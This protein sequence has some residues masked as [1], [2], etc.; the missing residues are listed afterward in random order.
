MLYN[1]DYFISYAHIDNQSENGNPG[2]VDQFV[3]KLQ[4]SAKH[5]QLF[6][7]KVNV[8]FDKTVIHN[9]SDWDNL[10]RSG[11]ASSRFLI[12]L[13]S[14]AFFKSEYCARVF[15]W[16]MQHE[17]HR[18]VLGE[19]TVPLVIADVPG[20]YDFSD[21]ISGIPAELLARYPN[22]LNQI[23]KIQSDAEFDLRNFDCSKIDNVLD[24]LYNEI[25]DRVDRQELAESSPNN[26]LYP[27]YNQ[28]FV[29]RRENLIVL[30]KTFTEKVS[31]SHFVLAGQGGIG[32]TELAITYGH[33]FAWDYQLGRVFVNCENK[34]SLFEV[35]LSCGLAE[36]NGWE[37]PRGTEE[38]QI[39][40]LFNHLK[41]KR[42]LI[43]HRNDEKGTLK[44]LGAHI[45]LILDNVN[46]LEL[47][48]RNN[49]DMLPDF[50]HVVITT[51]ESSNEYPYID[52]EIVEGL[53]EEESVE[54]LNNLRPFANPDEAN[55]ARNIAKLL[56]GFPL[57]V[58][59]TGAYL[60]RNPH[61]TYQMI[62]DSLVS[63][64]AEAFQIMAEKVARLTRCPAEHVLDMQ[65]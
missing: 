50:F 35:L 22:W 59:L 58:E 61:S 7:G 36:M 45:F 32:K 53:S 47:I 12:V 2:F 26:A 43:V 25:K 55:A 52:S 13:L 15:E 14:P 5:R 37:L 51:R 31:A 34:T 54:L 38:Q 18:C 28:N 21:A 9:M 40:F 49:L 24:S 19:G 62:Y 1:Y 23:R 64:H 30:R 42:D 46:K 56:A 48:S 65:K 11:L 17:M 33:A 44:T 3:E 29:G 27:R 60:S 57:A 63:N 16:W 20:L 4:N 41:A 6:G 39:T 10:I 8:F